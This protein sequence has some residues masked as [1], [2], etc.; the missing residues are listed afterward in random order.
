MRA[1][2]NDSKQLWYT[3]PMHQWEIVERFTQAKTKSRRNEDLIV[4]LG[5]GYAV[6]DGVSDKSGR[7]YPWNG[8]RV[9]SGYWAAQTVATILPAIPDGVTPVLAARMLTAAFDQYLQQVAPDVADADRPGATVMVFN[10]V[11]Q[12]LWWV[13]DCQAAYRTST[14]QLH[15]V[16]PTLPTDGIASQFRAAVVTAYLLAGETPA[17]A[18]EKGAAAIAPL[19]Q[20]QTVFANLPTRSVP[21]SYGVVNGTPIPQHHVGHQKVPDA[22]NTLVLATDGYPTVVFGNRLFTFAEAE[23]HLAELLRS[24]PLCID[25]LRSTKALLAGDTSFDDRAYLRITRTP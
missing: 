20:N 14:G 12:E 9:S 10:A 2:D 22:A 23:A 8:E 15:T 17:T 1:G 16:A 3:H 13:A 18:N 21:Y 19:L 24:D 4:D 7:E 25:S 5:W 6:V 11:R